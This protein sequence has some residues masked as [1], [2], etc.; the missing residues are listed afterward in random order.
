MAS[1]VID[2][3]DE[4]AR[5]L[6][7]SAAKRQV[8]VECAA[9]QLLEEQRMRDSGATRLDVSIGDERWTAKM[10]MRGLLYTDYD[11][12]WTRLPAASRSA[13]V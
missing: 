4:L 11:T 3:T 1:I 10:P 7:T 6:E 13:R 12:E 9:W 2:L 5:W 8:S